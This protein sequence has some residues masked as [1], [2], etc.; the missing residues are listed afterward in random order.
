MK[1][2]AYR[3][4][5]IRLPIRVLLLVAVLISSGC[6]RKDV[7]TDDEPALTE[8]ILQTDWFPQPEHGG[9]YQALAKGFYLEEGLDVTILPGGPNAM[10]TQ[11]VLKG[12]AHFAMNRADT[13]Y[14]LAARDVPVLMVMATLQHDPQAL[15]M[16]ASNPINSFHDLNG[17]QVMA[18]P[19]LT[20]VNWIEAKYDIKLDIIPHDF[21]LERFLNDEEFVQQCLLTNEPYYVRRAGAEVKVMPLRESG[22]DPYHGIYCLQALAKSQPDLVR[23]FVRASIRGWED[24]ILNDPSPAFALISRKN[25]KMTPDFMAYSYTTMKEQNLV[26]GTESDP[27]TIG[28]LDPLRLKSLADELVRLGVIDPE[29]RL[30]TEDWVTTRFLR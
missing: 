27:F 10:S 9:F 20:W 5:R 25:P 29:K 18:I 3:C 11:K 19:G 30:K 17:R 12:D 28:Q 13:I 14:S 16:H 15:L 7:K 2:P 22:F 23:R 4:S 6:G 24:Y 8:V 26:T 21:G 1:L